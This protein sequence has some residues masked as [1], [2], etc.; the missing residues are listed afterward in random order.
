MLTIITSIF[1]FKIKYSCLINY[2]IILLHI[3]IFYNLL[4]IAVVPNSPSG[5]TKNASS[6]LNLSLESKKWQKSKL[7]IFHY[8]NVFNK[9][10]SELWTCYV[11]HL[12]QVCLNGELLKKI[13]KKLKTR[14]IRKER[15][16]SAAPEEGDNCLS[17]MSSPSF[18]GG[19]L[20]LK[21]TLSF[22]QHHT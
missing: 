17:L 21:V 1:I 9:Y 6:M 10:T 7:E 20:L 3:N 15:R 2:L 4:N 5:V 18:N 11:P 8:K 19:Q 22:W 13:L 16:H 12:Y 14:K